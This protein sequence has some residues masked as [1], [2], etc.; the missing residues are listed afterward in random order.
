MCLWQRK[1]I[2]STGSD[3]AMDAA[4]NTGQEPL[5]SVA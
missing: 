5:V 4:A 2:T 3:T 1:K